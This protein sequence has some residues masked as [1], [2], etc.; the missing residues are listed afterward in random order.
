VDS[1]RWVQN[2]YIGDW[3]TEVTVVVDNHLMETDHGP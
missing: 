1:Q 2:L 3:L